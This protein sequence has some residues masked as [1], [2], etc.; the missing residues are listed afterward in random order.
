MLDIVHTL[1]ATY[2]TRRKPETARRDSRDPTPSNSTL[3]TTKIAA[4]IYTRARPATTI[5]DRQ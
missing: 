4:S 2:G 1:L 5:T 3:Q